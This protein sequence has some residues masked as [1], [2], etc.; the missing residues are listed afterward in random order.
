MVND[1]S[2]AFFHANA[3]RD[4]YV[5]LLDEEKAEG[6]EGMCSKLNISMYGTRDAAQNWQA[7]FS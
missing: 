2:R 1:V 3:T 6:E 7:E 4:V 5:Q